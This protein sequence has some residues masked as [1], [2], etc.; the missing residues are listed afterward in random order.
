MTQAGTLS[1]NFHVTPDLPAGNTTSTWMRNCG[2]SKRILTPGRGYNNGGGLPILCPRIKFIHSNGMS[3]GD[4]P[5]TRGQTLT[6][7]GF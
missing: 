3:S 7:E 1:S 4:E 2:I 6:H 5:M